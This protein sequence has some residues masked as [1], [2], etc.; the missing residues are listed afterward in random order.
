MGQE[1]QQVEQ[2]QSV[3]PQY[4]RLQCVRRFDSGLPRQSPPWVT[5]FCRDK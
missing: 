2:L 1:A 5:P 3:V 4:H